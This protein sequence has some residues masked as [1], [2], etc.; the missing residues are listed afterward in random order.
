MTKHLPTLTEAR[1]VAVAESRSNSLIGRGLTS[2]Q[3]GAYTL[4]IADRDALYRKARDA[5][6]R[7]LA[8]G[9]SCGWGEN[10]TPDEQAELRSAFEVFQRLADVG[11]GK[12]YFPL[13]CFYAGG[14]HIPGD[15]ERKRHY[16][17]KAFDWCFAN[18]LQKDPEIWNDLGTLYRLGHGGKEDTANEMALYWYRQSAESG[19]AGA[20]FNLCDMY[21]DGLGVEQDSKEARF[22]QIE[23]AKAGHIHAQYGLGL[24][25]EHNDDIFD[26]GLVPFYWFLQAAER[27]HRSATFKVARMSWDGFGFPEHDD[28]AFD[29]YVDKAEQGEIWAQW[30]LADAYRNGRGIDR[31]DVEAALWYRQAAQL[32]EPKAQWQLGLM[33][34]GIPTHTLESGQVGSEYDL[35]QARDWLEKAAAEGMPEA[36]HD[37]AGLLFEMGEVDEALFW[38]EAASDQGYGPAQLARAEHPVIDYVTEDEREN[39]ID[40]AVA[41]YVERVEG[42]DAERQYEYA[43]MHLRDEIP[44]ASREEGLYWLRRSA[45]Q[46]NQW[47]CADLG[48]NLLNDSAGEEMTREAI[49]WLEHAAELESASACEELGDLYLLGHAGGIHEKQPCPQLVQPNS[50]LAVEWYER[51]IALGWRAIA[52]RLGCLYLDGKHLLQDARLAEKWLLHAANAG[53]DSAQLVLGKEYASGLRLKRNADLAIQ[54]LEKAADGSISASL[55]IGKIL[56][57]GGLVPKDF[58]KAIRL[59][60]LASE[61]GVFRVQ[62]MKIVAN[63][64]TDTRSSSDEERQAKEW[65]AIQATLAADAIEDFS[66]PLV[67]HNL[68][69]LAEIYEHGL[70]VEPDFQHA[71]RYYTE[72][73]EYGLYKAKKRLHELGIDWDNP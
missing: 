42:G 48:R 7:I 40:Q 67:S 16:D 51:G 9:S 30:F 71:I 37:L 50:S 24:Q 33:Y 26:D 36:Q 21:E 4:A 32:G 55:E 17:K 72:A 14:Q 69:H 66:D 3:S 19:F 64:C 46:G 53:H 1:Q 45:E 28:L 68:L 54:W 2:I 31:D 25:Y 38:M 57:D 12:A 8:D 56:I 43:L 49:L 10:C 20:M 18:Q 65:L 29:W 61:S 59:L 27:G 60:T 15:I 73:A 11:Y 63:A 39:L 5:Y 34:W 41:W 52:Y 58:N 70:G 22:W 6:N 44:A 23:A 62:A 13:S 47:A 35:E